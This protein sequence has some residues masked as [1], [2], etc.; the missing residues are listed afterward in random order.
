[1]K[2]TINLS[3]MSGTLFYAVGEGEKLELVFKSNYGKDVEFAMDADPIPSGTPSFKSSGLFEY[4]PKAIDVESFN[5]KIAVE[6]QQGAKKEEVAINITPLPNLPSE[7][8]YIEH[9]AVDAIK[10]KPEDELYQI[11]AI[12]DDEKMVFNNTVEYEDEAID[13]VKIQTKKI[14]I[15]GVGLTFKKGNKNY[16]YLYNGNKPRNDLRR[17][18][19]YADEIEIVDELNLPGTDVFIYARILRF[20]GNGKLITTP[21]PLSMQSN[22]TKR[23]EGL[24][25][26]K[27]GDV[28][29]YVNELELPNTNK[30]L[31]CTNGA[32]GQAA[33]LGQKG[34]PGESFT[35]W[36]GHNTV[37]NNLFGDITLYWTSLFKSVLGEAK[38]VYAKIVYNH[39]QVT[40][41]SSQ[42]PARIED[43][44]EKIYEY[45]VEKYPTSGKPPKILPGVPG[46]G[47]NGGSIVST[48]S[49]ESRVEQNHGEPGEMAKDIK[50]S[51]AGEPRVSCFVEAEVRGKKNL[52]WPDTKK[53]GYLKL[54]GPVVRTSPGPGAKAPSPKSPEG[55]K[56]EYNIVKDKD[57]EW[58]QPANIKA[59]IP[60]LQDMILAG[61][62]N[63]VKELILKYANSLNEQI[64]R[65]SD[66]PDDQ[67][68]NLEWSNLHS[69]LK[70][71]QELVEGPYDYFGNPAGWVPF[72]SFESNLKIYEKE[73]E[74]SIHPLF[75]AYWVE[76]NQTKKLKAETALNGAIQQLEKENEEAVKDYNYALN[77]LIHL[78]E[79]IDII[80]RDTNALKTS[81]FAQERE[82]KKKVEKDLAFEHILRSSTKILGGLMQL[83]PVGQPV[84]GSIGK[85]VTVLSDIDLDKPLD[86]A[87]DFAGAFSGIASEKLIPKVKKFLN[88]YK[89]AEEDTDDEEEDKEEN[90]KKDKKTDK[91]TKKDSEKAKIEAGI[92]KK[93]LADKVKKYMDEQKEAREN[94]MDSFSNF[95]VKKD[96]IENRLNE[97]KAKCP[98]YK[99]IIKKIEKLN[100]K[101]SETHEA[102][103]GMLQK[104]E[105]STTTLLTNQ[106]SKIEFRYQLDVLID[107]LSP[108]A[109]QYANAMGNRAK[110]RMQKYLYYLL[111]SFHYLM[112]EDLEKVDFRLNKVFEKFAEILN[113]SPNGMLN[114]N[115]FKIIKSVF[116]DQLKTIQDKIIDYYTSHPFSTNAVSKVTLNAEQLGQLNG[117]TGE[118]IIDLMA[119]GYIDLTQ[120]QVLISNIEVTEIV[121][122]DPPKKDDPALNLNLIFEHSGNSQ[123]RQGGKQYIFR[124]GDYSLA[125]N[126]DENETKNPYRNDKMHWG[127][128]LNHSGE[129]LGELVHMKPDP[130][131]E[132]LVRSLIGSK[133]NR[134]SDVVLNYYPSAWAKIRIQSSH[135]PPQLSRAIKRLVFKINYIYTSRNDKLGTVHVRVPED[136]SPYIQFS[137]KDLNGRK[138]GR[139]SFLRTFNKELITEIKITAQRKYGTQPF[140]G[141]RIINAENKAQNFEEGT[142]PLIPL[143][144]DYTINLDLNQSLHYI[145]EPVYAPVLVS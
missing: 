138:D 25:G 103:I 54:I 26:Q 76:H 111:K 119:M 99:E 33:R 4:T 83:V 89:S 81:L 123:V 85:G 67:G 133:T 125:F 91:K 32:N 20:K 47:G 116:E 78:N 34:E 100:E 97:V 2:D 27:G 70:S 115:Q 50:G 62:E 9:K 129:G 112:I 88:E 56:G 59:L 107:Q 55:K 110:K 71:I 124:S 139:G 48:R 66:E 109:R 63:D 101:K 84:L 118:V 30:I 37:R 21:L 53:A 41:G 82:M 68:L 24:T 72:L 131:T 127:S 22:S 17:L 8:R 128:T 3:K 90:N 108:E 117:S 130:A 31:I 49:L 1:M 40:P 11:T 143:T 18:T 114:P 61:Y 106:F 15:S 86:S 74:D 39:K 14:S 126:R 140:L 52:F 113:D 44:S 69:E 144:P 79:K 13:S 93:K 45:G 28:Y 122:K 73:I 12:Q 10:P 98:E 42:V 105:D 137:E 23:D 19:L 29:L 94:V 95:T 120:D 35:V 5:V 104:I 46:Q 6:Q 87:A 141:W 16:K 145:I 51:A 80:K 136:V 75:F 36:H 77:E 7:F 64:K 132:S 134:N 135:T 58:L 121:L 96:E 43:V 38:P 92:A 142:F 60:Y 57:L 65:L 102:L